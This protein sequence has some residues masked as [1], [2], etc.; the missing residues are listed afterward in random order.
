MEPMIFLELTTR[1]T[2]GFGSEGSKVLVHLPVDHVEQ[3]FDGDE[4][5]T[6][7]STGGGAHLYVHETLTEIKA[8]LTALSENG[9][10]VAWAHK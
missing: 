9:L 1:R 10:S 3:R 6:Y 4:E 5:Y 2:V 8:L 7:V